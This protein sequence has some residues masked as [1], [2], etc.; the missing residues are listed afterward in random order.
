MNLNDEKIIILFDGVCNMCV[1]SIQ[2][3]IK[4]DSKDLFRLAS[5]QSSIGQNIIKKYSINIKKNDS[6][7]FINNNR[8]SYRSTAILFILNRLNTFWKIL[9]IF[10]IIPYPIRDF[11]YI[12]IAKSRYFLFGRR[13]KCIIPNENIKSKFLNIS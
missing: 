5:I 7:I 3:I 10:Y 9:L 6:L 11:I 12:L 8:I 1:K 13:N 2:F 4:K